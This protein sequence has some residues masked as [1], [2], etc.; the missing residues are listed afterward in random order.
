[1]AAVV[2]VSASVMAATADTVALQ[3]RCHYGCRAAAVPDATV[4]AGW[5]EAL[6]W[7]AICRVAVGSRATSPNPKTMPGINGF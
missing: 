4:A 6:P 7:L 5:V 1:M 2:T 3:S